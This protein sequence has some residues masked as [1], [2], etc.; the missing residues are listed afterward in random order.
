MG[1]AVHSHFNSFGEGLKNSLNFMVL[2]FPLAANI[3]IT[4]SSVAKRLKEVE[5]HFSG[6]FPYFLSAKFCVPNNPITAS[7][8]Y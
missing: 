3:Q 6:H 1:V 8:V 2:I 5:E 4:F 7:K